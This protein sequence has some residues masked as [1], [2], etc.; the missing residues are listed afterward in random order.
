MRMYDIIIKK[1]NGEALSDEEIAYFIK[2]YTDGTIPD[3]QASDFTQ[4]LRGGS[5]TENLTVVDSAGSIYCKQ[6]TVYV[7]DTAAVDVKQDG[8]TRFI[9][10]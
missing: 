9:C 2:G 6:I 4:F 7:V 3:Y 5:C 1:R 10:E 8:T